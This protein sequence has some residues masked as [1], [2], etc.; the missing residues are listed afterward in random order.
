MEE[1]ALISILQSLLLAL[2]FLLLMGAGL[3]IAGVQRKHHP[4]VAML[5]AAGFGL[6]LAS[7]FS[8][9]MIQGIVAGIGSVEVYS[10]GVMTI[11]W[12]IAALVDAAGLAAL[13]A[14]VV[15]GRS[16]A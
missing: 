4:R 13:L 16:N 10:S 5:S 3:G 8:M 7:H 15:V 12:G 6:L 9:T 2:P 11:L 1:S 14:A